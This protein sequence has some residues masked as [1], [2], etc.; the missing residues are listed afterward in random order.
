MKTIIAGSRYIDEHEALSC[1]IE[2]AIQAGVTP[3]FVLEGGARG[4]DRLGRQ[5]A[6]ENRIPFKTYHADFTTLGPRAGPL[7]NERM[8]EDAEALI[9]VW[10]GELF[11]EG[12][13]GEI[14]TCGTYDMIERAKAK[15]LKVF[16]LVWPWVERV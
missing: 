1:A 10:D 8:A 2:G 12:K 5:W 11:R 9:A 3:T 13:N 14:R 4:V 7:R 6:I 16:V 15:G